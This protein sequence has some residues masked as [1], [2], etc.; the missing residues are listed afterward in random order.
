MAMPAVNAST[1]TSI[2][3]SCPAGIASVTAVGTAPTMNREATRPTRPP[4]MERTAASASSNCTRRARLAPSAVRTAISRVRDAALLSTSVATLAHVTRS[5]RPT[6]PRSSNRGRCI[7]PTISSRRGAADRPIAKPACCSDGWVV[8][9]DPSCQDIELRSGLVDRHAALQPRDHAVIELAAAFLSLSVGE[10]HRHPDAGRL[11]VRLGTA[12]G[13]LEASGHD[14]DHRVRPAVER[15]GLT[16]DRAVASVTRLPEA[17]AQHRHVHTGPVLLRAEI[18]AQQR[19]DAE[20]REQ[21]RRDLGAI[22]PDRLAASRE[23]ERNVHV[24]RHALE[25]LLVALEIEK[26]RRREG[27]VFSRSARAR[28]RDARGPRTP[29][30]G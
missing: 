3:N 8:G 27:D 5:T 16:H 12:A 9:I 11:V 30:A 17:P 6:A 7:R 21:A 4:A 20:Q 1:R 29:A 19:A 28:P 14:A 25:R 23:L 13:E 26:V 15:D 18:A 10:R 2:E 24:R 22:D